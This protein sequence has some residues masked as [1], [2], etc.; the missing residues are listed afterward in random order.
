MAAP[1]TCP[2][3][4][5]VDGGVYRFAC[6]LLVVGFVSDGLQCAVHATHCLSL[7]LIHVILRCT[8]GIN[9]PIQVGFTDELD[10]CVAKQE[11][12]V[13]DILAAFFL[14]PD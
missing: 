1:S 13:T 11:P 2:R 4:I 7:P 10:R 12:T 3:G 6:V 5:V 8:G 9:L 14:I